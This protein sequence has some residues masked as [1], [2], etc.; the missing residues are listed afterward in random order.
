M[1]TNTPII[2]TEYLPVQ[3]ILSLSGVL[4]DYLNGNSK[5]KHLV[6]T[7]PKIESLKEN[8]TQKQNNYKFRKEF[9]T[10][11]EKQMQGFPI[12]KNQSA[13]F[14]KLKGENTF[15]ITTAHQTNLFGGPLYF[16]QKAL[17]AIK[18][19]ELAKAEFPKYNFVP[20]YWLGS[21]DHDFEELNHTKVF[22]E[23]YEWH[24]KQ[25]G[26]F[27]RY[28]TQSLTGL[29]NR[30]KKQFGDTENDKYLKNLFDK[31]FGQNSNIAQATRVVLNE[32]LGEYGLLI[33]DGDDHDLKKL[34]IPVFERELLYQFS[35]EACKTAND[36]LEKEYGTSQAYS[37]EINLFYLTD[38]FRGRIELA[39][40]VYRVRGS[41][42][43]FS[44]EE[45]LDELYQFPER[46]SPNVFLRPLMQEMIL[47][48]LMYVGG[49]GELSY[50]FQLKPIFDEINCAYP[51]LGL[52]DAAIYIDEKSGKKMEKIDLS[53]DDLTFT[54][55]QLIQKLVKEKT[56]N[57]LEL[58]EPKELIEKAMKL[59]LEQA[60]EIDFTLKAS[61][62]AEEQRINNSLS[63]LEKKMLRAEKRNHQILLN[64][65]DAI[66]NQVYPDGK[67]QERVENFSQYY[68][69]L[70]VIWLDWM[71]DNFNLFDQQVKVMRLS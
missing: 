10:V 35:S 17:S 1:L 71:Y 45:I 64:R 33:I 63:N 18:V 8:I 37:R 15:C 12:H 54:K 49:G 56:T 14:L 70:G 23:K 22:G 40:E 60:R 65:V 68:A 5:L 47:P 53:I 9:L 55:E 51:M 59:M 44:K 4:Q 36:F 62:A 13:N 42:L 27:G 25:N 50:W 34:M 69:Q 43:R 57:D 24:D 39:D 30:L 52:R 28:S 26:A 19:C 61:A 67:L 6:S 41:E 31:A 20:V 58:S 32:L 11:L 3:K 2:T 48:N 66:Y 46:F 7:F 38:H 16:I 21:E 29:L